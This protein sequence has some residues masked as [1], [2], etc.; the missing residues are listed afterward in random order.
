M[1]T[2]TTM[3]SNNKRR[4]RSP[5]PLSKGSCLT[6]LVLLVGNFIFT[7][8]NFRSL[9]RLPIQRWHEKKCSVVAVPAPA[10]AAM[11]ANDSNDYSDNRTDP[12]ATN[13]NIRGFFWL[14]T[15]LPR[16][17]R[18]KGFLQLFLT[19]TAATAGVDLVLV[20]DARPPFSTAPQTYDTIACRGTISYRWPK[21]SWA[22]CPIV[23]F[24]VLE[25][26]LQSQQFLKTDFGLPVA[27][28]WS[29]ATT[30]DNDMSLGNVSAILAPFLVHKRPQQQQQQEA[31]L[32]IMSGSWG[33]NAWGPLTLYPN[34]DRI[35]RLFRHATI[36]MQEIFGVPPLYFFRRMAPLRWRL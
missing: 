17:R 13:D 9:V 7:E 10:A 30:I 8:K 35:N 23:V 6:M 1:T 14:P 20:G 26:L 15:Y 32:D 34:I 12:P 22:F 5:R 2:T 28:N 3:R 24:T 27:P 21:R 18:K 19:T 25:G 16:R 29:A 31:P 33:V 36:S 11:M 4:S